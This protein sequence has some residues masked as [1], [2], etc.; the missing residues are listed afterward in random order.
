MSRRRS[1]VALVGALVAAAWLLSTAP[2]AAAQ[3]DFD[4]GDFA[5][6]EEAQAVYDQ[7]PSDPYDLDGDGDGIAC[8]SLPSGGSGGGSGGGDDD[9]GQVPSGGVDTG[10]GGMAPLAGSQGVPWTAFAG[11]GGALAAAAGL[12]VQRLPGRAAR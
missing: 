4:C 6:Q 5:T 3:Q 7:D 12:A 11:A 1:F 9:G 10:A 2:S 8:E